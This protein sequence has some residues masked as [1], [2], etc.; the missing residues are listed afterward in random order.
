MEVPDFMGCVF[1]VRCWVPI[2]VVVISKPFDTVLRLA[3]AF[4][5]S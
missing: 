2:R 1:Q 3:A 5:Y 4:S